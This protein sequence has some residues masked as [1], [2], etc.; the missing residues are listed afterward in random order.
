M[1]HV[2]EINNGKKTLIATVM[3]ESKAWM[4]CTERTSVWNTARGVRYEYARV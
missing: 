3:S 4:L 2:F 1:W